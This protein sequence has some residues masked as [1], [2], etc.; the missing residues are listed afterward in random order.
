MQQTKIDALALAGFCLSGG[1]N[2]VDV[3]RLK[4][5]EHLKRFRG[6]G[7]DAIREIKNPSLSSRGAIWAALDELLKDAPEP[8]LRKAAE[9]VS[10]GDATKHMR[11]AEIREL[12]QR[13]KFA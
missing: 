12:I 6:R 3:K 8:A 5:E 10:L 2:G 11:P 13:S 1:L 7:A 4:D 9:E